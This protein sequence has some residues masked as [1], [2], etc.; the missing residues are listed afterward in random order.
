MPR[1]RVVKVGGSLLE[2]PALGRQLSAWLAAQ[3]AL[4]TLLV[5]GGGALA[6]AVRQFDRHRTLPPAVAHG[7][8][9]R[10][11]EVNALILSQLLPA[12]QRLTRLHAWHQSPAVGDT[13]CWIL[14]AEHFLQRDEPHLAG[15]RLPCGWQVTSD[16]IAARL[17]EVCQ[18]QDLVLLKSTL[19]ESRRDAF[20]LRDLA[21]AGL[22]DDH[23]PTAAASLPS[24][25]VVNLRAP[26]FPQIIVAK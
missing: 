19:P 18:A 6:D 26:D 16:S 10:A 13:S 15:T 5:A 1:C 7:M 20:S 25:R 12:A 4:P 3:P 14:M 24:I 8:A 2:W 22:V 9:I 23:F 11:M 21:Q 17:A